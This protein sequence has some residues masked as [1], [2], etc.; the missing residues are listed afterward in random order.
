M[1][2]TQAM[3]TS[4]KVGVLDGT[5]DFSSGTAQTFKIALFTS[6]ATLDATTTAYSV[7]NEV[8]GTGYTAGGETLTISANPASTGTTAFLDF[9]DVTWSSATITARGALIYLA[10][11][12]TNPAVAVLD[13]GSDKTSTAGDFTIVFPAADASNAIIRIA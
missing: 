7:T 3:V 13:F 6:S 4:F 10:D 12:G 5:F 2:I 1:A 11:G 9:S 8:S